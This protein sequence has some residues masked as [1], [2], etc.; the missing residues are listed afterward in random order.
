MYF[1]PM[2]PVVTDKFTA[3]AAYLFFKVFEVTEETPDKMINRFQSFNKN[4]HKFSALSQRTSA[5]SL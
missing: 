2:I 1:S 5:S 4:F 3:G